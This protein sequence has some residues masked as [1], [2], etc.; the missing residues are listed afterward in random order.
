MMISRDDRSLFNCEHLLI[1]LFSI[2]PAARVYTW[3]TRP[4][5]FIRRRELASCHGLLASCHGLDTMIIKRGQMRTRA[6]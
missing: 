2:G 1:I 4:E 5:L 6:V 3:R